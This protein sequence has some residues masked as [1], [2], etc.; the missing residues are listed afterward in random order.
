VAKRVLRRTAAI[1]APHLRAGGLVLGL[2]PSCTAVFHSDAPDLFPEDH[3]V[4]R[5]RN[6]T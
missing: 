1:L 4:R 6:Q 3:D 5:L 2:E